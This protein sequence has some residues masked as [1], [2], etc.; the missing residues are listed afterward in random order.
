MQVTVDT[1]PK[2]LAAKEAP[3]AALP[4]I[5]QLFAN[6]IATTDGERQF[7]T[8]SLARLA[9]GILLANATSPCA[10]EALAFIKETIRQLRGATRGSELQ[11][12]TW[13]F[14]S[15]QEER[16]PAE[17][18]LQITFDG[19]RRFAV[20]FDKARQGLS[21]ADLLSTTAKNLGLTIINAK[22]EQVPY[23]P[24]EQEDSQGGIR[25]GELVTVLEPGLKY[26]NTVVLRALV[27]KVGST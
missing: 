5:R 17:G 2:I 21:A 18:S 4:F 1:L 16:S 7:A 22:G 3:A 19:A 13:I 25:P 23:N 8:A 14:E 11:S 9:T 6:L 10:K 12:Q 27:G 15:L 26:Q 20:A 24:L